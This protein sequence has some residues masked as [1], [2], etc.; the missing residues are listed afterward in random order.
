[1]SRPLYDLSE[2]N[3]FCTKEDENT[4]QVEV[5]TTCNAFIGSTQLCRTSGNI[6][7]PDGIVTRKGYGR[8]L[9]RLLVDIAT[10][11]GG[12]LAIVRDGDARGGALTVWKE[13]FSDPTLDK[14]NIEKHSYEIDWTS[15]EDDPQFF[16][17]YQSN[18]F[19]FVNKKHINHLS[20]LNKETKKLA[21]LGRSIFNNSYEKD[22]NRWI[23]EEYPFLNTI[24]T[25]IL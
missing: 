9:H 17:A 18:K 5:W 15:I 25:K 22:D 12:S 19:R 13:F 6:Y 20:S 8:S 24:S 11:L 1:M 4:Y 2:C 7:S 23:D 21:E 16:Y 3:I 10:D 14:I